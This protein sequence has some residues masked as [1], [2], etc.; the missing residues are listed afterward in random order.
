VQRLHHTGKTPNRDVAPAFI[1]AGEELPVAH[2]IPKGGVGD[3]VGG[4]RKVVN[5]HAHLAHRQRLVRS[6]VQ[7]GLGEL[8]FADLELCG[9]HGVRSR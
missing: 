6:G 5:T 1:G 2:R 7:A 3:V 8:V 4:E 9:V